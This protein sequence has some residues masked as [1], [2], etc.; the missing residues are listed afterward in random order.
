MA[1][2]ARGAPKKS[3]VLTEKENGSKHTHT[4]KKVVAR[5]SVFKFV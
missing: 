2:K 1:Q 5:N 3:K 4:K